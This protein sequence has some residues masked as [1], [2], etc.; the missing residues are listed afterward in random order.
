MMAA[1]AL[2]DM[3]QNHLLQLLVL[4]AM[5]PPVSFDADE[6]RNRKVD[7]LKAMRKF[8]PDDVRMST[9]RGQYGKGW[10]EGKQ[11]PAIPRRTKGR[12]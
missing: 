8:T 4:I 12:S 1:G 2:R 11:V 10:M 9:V 6:V 5:E 7:V 3:I